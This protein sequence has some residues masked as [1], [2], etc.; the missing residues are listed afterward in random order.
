M[1]RFTSSISLTGPFF[2]RDPA[3]TFGRNLADMGEAM[4]EEAAKDVIARMAGTRAPVSRIGGR[5]SDR[6]VHFTKNTGLGKTDVV[7]TL[8]RRGLSVEEVTALDAAGSEVESRTRAWRR[9]TDR[10]RCARAVN[11]AE[12]LKGIE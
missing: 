3:K 10:M 11:R 5:V 7:V 12:L 9:T 6:V 1:S 8:A 4:A 2:R